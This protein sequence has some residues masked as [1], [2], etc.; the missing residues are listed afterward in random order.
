MGHPADI[1]AYDKREIN[2][3]CRESEPRFSGR[4]D[5]EYVFVNRFGSTSPIKYFIKTI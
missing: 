4:P 5:T 3:S 1:G 2:F